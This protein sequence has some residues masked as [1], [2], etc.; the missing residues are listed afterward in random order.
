MVR[1]LRKI[2]PRLSYTCA[3]LG[4]APVLLNHR[5]TERGEAATPWKRLRLA[6]KLPFVRSG[7]FD[8]V[9]SAATKG[10]ETTGLVTLVSGTKQLTDASLSAARLTVLAKEPRGKRS[11]SSSSFLDFFFFQSATQNTTE[12]DPR[13]QGRRLL[14]LCESSPSASK[15]GPCPAV[16]SHSGRSRSAAPKGG[17]GA[18]E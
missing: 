7:R 6:R 15:S 5:N 2:C 1:P 10:Q 12:S 3:S 17:G 8:F 18:I 11:S 9:T 4:V 14:S 16:Y 13:D